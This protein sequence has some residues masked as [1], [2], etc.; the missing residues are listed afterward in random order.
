MPKKKKAKR[1]TNTWYGNKAGHRKAAKKGVRTKKRKKATRSRAAKAA[2]RK[3]KA[4]YGKTGVKKRGRKKATVKRKPA[5]RRKA[6]KKR[7]RKTTRK[8]APRKRKT[9]RKRKSSSASAAS[10]KAWRTRKRL[11][12]PSGL[13]KGR[14]RKLAPGGSMSYV[15][16]PR[17]RKKGKGRR[18]RNSPLSIFEKT[19]GKLPM[20]GTYFQGE[21]LKVSLG[22]GA[23]IIVATAGGR[24]VNN[25][26]M[27]NLTFLQRVPYIVRPI[28]ILIVGGTVSYVLTRFFKKPKWAKYVFLGAGGAAAA[29]VIDEALNMLFATGGAPPQ[30]GG[31]EDYVQYGD[32]FGDQYQVEAGML[33]MDDYVQMAGM[34]GMPGLSDQAAVEAGMLNSFSDYVQM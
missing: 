1:R 21:N 26:L 12:G 14:R 13:A 8:A 16:N 19:L 2:W 11:Y 6:T 18:R 20:I 25:F 23:G 3:R 28:S 30:G 29:A 32:P 7:A 34:G 17:K 24:M 15:A 5:K 33:G 27:T 4:R 22:I 31:A 9:T 10:R